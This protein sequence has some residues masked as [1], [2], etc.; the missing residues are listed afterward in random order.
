MH[1]KKILQNRGRLESYVVG[2]GIVEFMMLVKV[3][4]VIYT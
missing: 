4:I 1:V 2:E 3:D